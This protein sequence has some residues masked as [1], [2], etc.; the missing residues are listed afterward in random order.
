MLSSR[1][2]TEHEN[3]LDLTADWE[4]ILRSCTTT[5]YGPDAT[6][7]SVWARA[8]RDTLLKD[9][10]IRVLVV[11]SGTQVAGIVPTYLK[12]ARA[13]PF[14]RRELRI[15]TEAYG[16]RRGLM[17]ANTDPDLTE[18]AL[19]RLRLDLPPWD[20]LLLGAVKGSLSHV[21]LMN[22]ARNTSLRARCLAVSQSPYIELAAS[23]E[24]MI[25]KLPK[26][27]R[28]TFRKGERDL[29][30]K[31]AVDYEQITDVASVGS[32]LAS[33]VA[34]ERK[35]WKEEVGT[36]ITAQSRQQAFYDTFARLAAANGIL[37]GHVLRVASQPIAY[38]LG[39]A[40]GDGVFLD[41]KESFD[42]SYAEYSP[43]HVLKRFAIEALIGRGIRVYDFMGRCEPYKMRWTDKTYQCE[44]IAL[45]N[46]T[47]RGSIC[48]LR[49]N[50]AHVLGSKR[51]HIE[52]TGSAS[53]AGSMSVS[54]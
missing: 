33:V 39:I 27:T 37:S 2:S 34:I 35:S 21:N 9:T 48:Y 47:V 23:W 29:T 52:S 1:I 41:L 8:L 7:S 49:S 6:C 22:A 31:G 24:A 3:L 26:K 4:R 53:A 18:F 32:L 15:I 43:G 14:D 38:I 45:Y 44:T 50:L 12:V 5:V 20:V 42:A 19:R 10:Q 30:A 25:A 17:I 28:W 51:Q 36:S 46:R 40:T 13:L 16:G 54:G 11:S